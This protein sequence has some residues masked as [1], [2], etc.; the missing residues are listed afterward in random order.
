MVS[1]D[2]LMSERKGVG[3][4]D[5]GRA[6]DGSLAEGCVPDGQ[7]RVAQP[8]HVP[9]VALV[10]L[11]EQVRLAALGVNVSVCPEEGHKGAG[12]VEANKELGCRVLREGKR[13][14]LSVS[15]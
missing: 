11:L 7:E 10:R 13:R 9:D 8:E 12:L 1:L 14:R 5:D 3:A 15:K 4:P 2:G 6:V